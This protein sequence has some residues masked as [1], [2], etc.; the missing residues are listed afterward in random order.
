[1][2]ISLPDLPYDYDALEPHLSRQ[3]LETHHAIHHR[4]LVDTVNRLTTGTLYTRMNLR[5]IL[6]RSYRAKDVAIYTNAAQAMN[7]EIFWNSLAPGGGGEPEGLL[8]D[9]LDRQ[10][11]SFANFV[12]EF[13]FSALTHHA[14]GWIWLVLDGRRLR[15]MKTQNAGCPIVRGVEPLLALDI[16]EHAYFLDYPDD[17]GRYVDTF[18]DQL[19]DWESAARRFAQLINPAGTGTARMAS[20]RR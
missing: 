5:D 18:L 11:G 6:L 2:P 9:T 14:S 12:D 15:I 17:R 7:H 13:R 19:A 4:H 10:F 3:S 8:V 20:V 1:M 16:W